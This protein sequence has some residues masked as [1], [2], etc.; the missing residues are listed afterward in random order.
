MRKIYSLKLLILSL[1]IFSCEDKAANQNSLNFIEI[2]TTTVNQ[3]DYLFNFDKGEKVQQEIST[4][5]HLKYH[6]IDTGTGYNMPNMLLNNNVLLNINSTSD[7]ESITIAPDR[8][9]FTAEGGRIQYGGSHSVL[10]YD[11]SIHKVGVS[12][13]VYVIYDTITNKIFKIIFDDYDGGVVVFRYA[14]LSN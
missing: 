1:I 7:F 2:I 6:N 5:W 13:D 14:E 9:S 4:S 8:G 3:G 11:M 12:S 10:S